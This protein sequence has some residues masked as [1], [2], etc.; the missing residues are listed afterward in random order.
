MTQLRILQKRI[1]EFKSK[2]GKRI[3]CCGISR[4][5][6]KKRVPSSIQNMFNRR[7]SNDKNEHE[8][9]LGEIHVNAI[10]EK[11]KLR[12]S[13]NFDSTKREEERRTLLQKELSYT[14]SDLH[15][16]ENGP[17]ASPVDKGQATEGSFNRQ[18]TVSRSRLMQA[19]IDFDMITCT[20]FY[21]YMHLIRIPVFLSGV[22]AQVTLLLVNA[23]HYPINIVGIICM[24]LRFGFLCFRFFASQTNI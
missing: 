12:P 10:I 13:K 24:S 18:T 16:S 7:N 9:P 6:E 19:D 2:T 17:R 1:K 14:Y 23:F 4:R 21:R 8:E 20:I 5:S 15:A 3:S 22:A 11:H